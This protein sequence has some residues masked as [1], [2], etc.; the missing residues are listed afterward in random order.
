VFPKLFFGHRLR[1]YNQ[2][3]SRDV[4]LGPDKLLMLPMGLSLI[5][6]EKVYGLV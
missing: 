3:T 2:L 5:Y 6:L 1:L 4:P